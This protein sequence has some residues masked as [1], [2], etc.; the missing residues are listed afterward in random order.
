MAKRRRTDE[1]YDENKICNLDFLETNSKIEKEK[2]KQ[3]MVKDYLLDLELKDYRR[4]LIINLNYFH[5]IC[6]SKEVRSND[7]KFLLI[8]K[9]LPKFQENYRCQL[10][11]IK[12]RLNNEKFEQRLK[13]LNEKI[14]IS[15]QLESRLI[16]MLSEHFKRVKFI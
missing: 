15:E 3:K 14:K 8:S 5:D 9:I 16:N 13:E 11:F 10:F 7:T 1:K 12:T 4:T 6:D 2:M